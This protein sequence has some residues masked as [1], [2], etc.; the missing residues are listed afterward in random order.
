LARQRWCTRRTSG[1]WTFSADGERLAAAYWDGTIKVWDIKSSQTMH[2][3][4]HGDRA[5]A[6]AFHPD[7]RQLASGSCDNT[8][9]VWNL[10]TG[11]EVETLGGHIGYVM[12]VAYSPDG[13]ILATCSGHRYQ[14][15][16]QLWNT[17]AF[18]T[19]R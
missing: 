9:K 3:F 1:S 5:M 12:C 6:V 15:E 8:A 2:T 16:V 18:G 7:G 14:G 11:Q 10:D 19:M 17:A 13:Q 4:R